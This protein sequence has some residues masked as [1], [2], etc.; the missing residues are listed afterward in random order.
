MDFGYYGGICVPDSGE[1][2]D[3]ILDLDNDFQTSIIST[4]SVSNKDAALNTLISLASQ[5]EA[6]LKTLSLLGLI[7]MHIF[8]QDHQSTSQI[9]DQMPPE[10]QGTETMIRVT[11]QIGFAYLIIGRFAESVDRFLKVLSSS[12]EQVTLYYIITFFL[13]RIKIIATS[14][15]RNLRSMLSHA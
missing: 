12:V 5:P 7:R 3:D 6:N 8:L 15:Q 14:R 13:H 10:I 11:Y 1:H 4:E 2:L 9:L